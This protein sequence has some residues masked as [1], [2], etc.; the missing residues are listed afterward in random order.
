MSEMKEGG[1]AAAPQNNSNEKE[2]F[3]YTYETANKMRK[4]STMAGA[5]IL[6]AQAIIKIISLGG[7]GESF[8]TILTGIYFT[9]IAV[10]L[11]LLEL[12]KSSVA[13]WFMFM[14]FALGKVFLYLFMVSTM[15][16]Y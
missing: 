16:S 1:E 15:L 11:V 8:R 3:G 6:I 13:Q 7:S 12:E 4:Y 9:M 14:N 10:I 5:G 2:V